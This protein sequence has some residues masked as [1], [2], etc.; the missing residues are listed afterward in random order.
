MPRLTCEQKE[1]LDRA[2][3]LG[4]RY[5][6]Q[7]RYDTIRLPSE[8]SDSAPDT[9]LSGLAAFLS[10]PPLVAFVREVTGTTRIDFADAHASRFLPG[11]F[12]T[13]HDDAVSA[14]G[15]RAAYVLNL[16]RAWRPDWGGLLLFYDG[17][18]SVARGYTPEFNALNLFA[19]PQPHSVSWVNPLAAAARYA[20]TGWLRERTEI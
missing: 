5:D 16:T 10:S 1:K 4:G 18:G 9:L 17:E 3:I 7:F 15:R 8:L 6:F 11:H 12:L 14:M 13:A 20:V 2:V 19:V